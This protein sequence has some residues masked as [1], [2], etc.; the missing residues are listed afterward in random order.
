MTSLTR[1][2]A[3]A[4]AGAAA[5]AP[6]AAFAQGEVYPSREIK[7]VCAFPAGSGADV[8]VRFFV[9][10]AKA[11][12]GKPMLVENRPGANGNIA[13]EFA[14]RSRADGYTLYIHSPTS[15]AANMF[16]FKNPPIDV[17]SS[18]VTVATL[19]RFTFYLTVDPKR[20]WQNVQELVAYVRE[21]G[22][23]ATFA[24]TAPSGR[25]MGHLLN[26]IMGLKAQEVQYRTAADHMNDIAS[27]AVDYSFTDGVFAHAQAR[28]GRL[29]I[30]GAG[31]KERMKSDPEVPTIIEQGV[32]GLYA[33]GFFGVMV[34]V[35]TPRPVIEQINGWFVEAVKLKSSEEFIH[36]YGGDPVISSPDEAQKMFVDALDE[37]GKLV[38]LS[39]I[40][41]AG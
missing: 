32:P 7:V 5:V 6:R 19:L 17:K 23:K 33:P 37:W 8:W 10:Q 4:L 24:T 38:E 31:S 28:A 14:A 9:E 36:K 18:L 3:L 2:N 25:L 20:P 30:L 16:M 22:D 21:K 35:G 11:L 15:L 39:K 34:P 1:R 40:Q 29:R 26:Q 41:P 27:G 12:V 13:T